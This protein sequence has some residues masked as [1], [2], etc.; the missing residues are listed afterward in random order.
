MLY[1]L[2]WLGF[3]AYATFLAP[4]DRPE[5]L[6]LI[7]NLASGK[8][9]GIN[10]LVIALFNLMGIWPLVYSAVLYADG[11]GQKVR[12]FPFAAGSFAV[13]AFALLPY[14]ALR[15]PNS[16]FVGEPSW[17]IRVMDSVWTGRVLLLGAIALLAYGFTQGNWADFVQQWQTSKFI[18]VMSLDF[19]ALSALFPALLQD[20]LARRGLVGS[21]WFWAIALVPLLGPLVYLSVRPP[22]AHATKFATSE[23]VPEVSL[24]G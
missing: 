7:Q 23:A 16:T 11:R 1:W 24:E 10:P 4:P 17:L 6:T 15:R 12:A 18:H 2:L 5:T 9:D 21:H 22:L 3:I 8:W 13:G 20:D 14:L 19:V